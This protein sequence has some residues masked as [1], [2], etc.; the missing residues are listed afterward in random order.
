MQD[1]IPLGRPAGIPVRLH[2]TWF[3]VAALV[4]FSLAESY[5]PGSARGYAGGAYWS[6]AVVV[7]L[8][9]FGSLL[10]HEL[11]HAV[12]ARRR[13][14]RVVGITLYLFGGVAAIEGESET[15]ADE[16]W[17]TVVGPL[18][19]V[20][21]AGLFGLLWAALGDTS[22][23]LGA[24]LG[25]LA[26]I[27]LSLALFNLLPG[28]PLDG[29]RLLRALVWWRTGDVGR[30]TQVAAGAGVA[31]GYG[32]IAVGIF[33]SFTGRFA[34]GLWFVF[35]GWYLQSMAERYRRQDQTRALFA[36]L[37]AGELADRAPAYVRPDD[38][39]DRIVDDV[40][41][42]RG[43]RTLPVLSPEPAPEAVP[44]PGGDGFLGL[45]T[46]AQIAQ[47]PRDAWSQTTAAQAMVPAA[48]LLAVRPDDP[49]E[50]AVALMSERDVNQVA[51]LDA[52]GRFYGLLS[53]ATVIRHLEVR[54]RLGPQERAAPAADRAA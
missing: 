44:G 33:W 6:A 36:G 49:L 31:L 16:F 3:L 22:R 23:L 43:V 54:A 29:G 53:R 35:L 41:L 27:N 10:V 46:L 1:S 11:A 32:L 47:V 4:V 7:A 5:L 18:S 17:I 28:F 13:G 40:L 2:A 19:S 24:M 42:P 30:A 12:T 20:A 8:L 50:R 37:R 38:R 9:F 15:A 52:E 25:Y 45:L 26:V 39:L 51:V 21:L 48:R 14:M 34:N